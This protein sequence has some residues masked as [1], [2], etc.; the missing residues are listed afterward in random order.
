MLDRNH[1]RTE[2]HT[3][4]G[5]PASALGAGA[6]YQDLHFAVRTLRKSPAFTVAAILTLALGIGANAAI[7]QLL[8]AVRLRSLP[9]PHPG[10]LA[11]I[12][13]QGGNPG[14][15]ISATETSLTYPIWEQIRKGSREY[16]RGPTVSS[17]SAKARSA[18]SPRDSGSAETR[19]RRSALL[20]S[21]AGSLPKTTTGRA[22]ALRVW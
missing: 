18:S 5:R 3:A 22:A 16:S 12:Q 21:A 6:L 7:F 1:S 19:S 10:G 2:V 20:P 15:G 4:K 9:V 8:N 13:I 17:P 14:F 11:V